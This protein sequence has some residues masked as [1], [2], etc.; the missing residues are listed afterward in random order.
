MNKNVYVVSAAVS[1]FISIICLFFN[2][3]I[4]TGIILGLI[5]S[6]LY[7]ILLNK[8]LTFDENGS[9][10]KGSFIFF[11]VRIMIL[12]FPL[13]IACLVPQYI[14]IFGTFGGV[15]IF[16]IVMIIMFIKKKGELK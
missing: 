1:I 3:K 11:I 15:M 8:N 10:K 5:S 4:S 2:W 16:R 14:N 6:F 7:F 12:A 13:L 9:I